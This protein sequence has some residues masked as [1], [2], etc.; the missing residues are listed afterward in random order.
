[1]S[2]EIYHNE[3]TYAL[4]DSYFADELDTEEKMQ[5][6]QKLK[7][8]KSFNSAFKE[9][10]LLHRGIEEKG[11]QDM[12]NDF[13]DELDNKKKP[14]NPFGYAYAIAA[15]LV[16]VIGITAWIIFF[17]QDPAQRL[18]AATFKPD[19]GLAT[20]MGE[21]SNYEFF[22]GMVNY[23]RA[24]YDK[25]IDRWEP[26]YNKAPD[27]DTLNYFLGVA[28]LASDKTVE[29]KK[30]LEYSKTQKQSVFYDDAHYYLA[31]SQ[32]KGNELEAA[33]K[34]LESSSTEKSKELLQKVENLKEK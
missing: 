7:Q 28:N 11:M 29:A 26:L 3:E 20:T 4:F 14:K 27:N 17:T 33:I 10:K 23:K 31:L 1:M 16:I 9:Y 8:D 12:L 19:P 5:F 24:E 21:Q 32:I 2:T 13:Q 18:Y 6:E 34:T 15:T 22:E 30:Y 25:A